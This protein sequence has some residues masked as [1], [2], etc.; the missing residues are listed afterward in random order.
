MFQ[1]KKWPWSSPSSKMSLQF[2]ALPSS[3]ATSQSTS[4]SCLT[5]AAASG[6]GSPFLS[7]LSA[8]PVHG[9]CF[10]FFTWNRQFYPIKISQWLLATPIPLH[11]KASIVKNIRPHVT[12]FLLMPLNSSSGLPPLYS[13]KPSLS[14]LRMHNAYLLLA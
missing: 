3:A 14:A 1:K 12:W 5:M 9:E 6:L 7:L 11:R 13:S 10:F 2:S 8:S 4:P